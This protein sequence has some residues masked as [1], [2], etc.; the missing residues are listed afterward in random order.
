MPQPDTSQID[1][2][3]PATGL[4]YID[5]CPFCNAKERDLAFENVQDWSFYSAPGKW[6]YWNCKQCY[7]LFLDPRPSIETIGMAYRSYYTHAATE[8]LTAAQTIKRRLRNEC[9]SHWLNVS[10][11]PRLNLPRLFGWLLAPLKS[12]IAIPFGLKELASFPKGKLIDVGC[13]SGFTVN[14][15]NT[16][17]WNAT[18]LE[19]D[20][21]AVKA[22]RSQGLNVF[23]GSYHKLSEYKNTFDVVVCS[24]VLEHV[25]DPINLL[26]LSIESLKNGGALLLSL[27]NSASQLRK[28]FGADWRGLEAPRHLAIPSSKWLMD[29]LNRNGMECKVFP[30]YGLHT[31]AESERIKRRGLAVEPDDMASIKTLRRVIGPLTPDNQDF[32][33]LVCTK[34]VN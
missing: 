19:M 25:H 28:H 15:A 21:T 20:A 1:Q 27:P 4:E 18:G 3:W 24:H 5:H 17:G 30:S 16:L 22:A 34:S 12:R 13:G 29:Y 32:T 26:A 33:Y 11:T 9:W 7:A 31:A 10:I 8:K 6:T 2:A 23:E 14:L